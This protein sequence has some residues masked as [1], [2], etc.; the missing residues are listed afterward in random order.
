M[1]NNVILLFH[2]L[3][4]LLGQWNNAILKYGTAEDQKWFIRA[5]LFIMKLD[6]ARGLKFT[7]IE[8]NIYLGHISSCFEPKQMLKK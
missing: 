7:S 2:I 4:D 3:W 6:K 1:S 8:A 5:R